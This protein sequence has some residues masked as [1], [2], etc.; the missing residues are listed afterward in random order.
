M[1]RNKPTP[2]GRELGAH[3]ARLTEVAIKDCEASTPGLKMLERCASCAFR[4]GTFPNGCPETLL[5][6]IDCVQSG[7]PFLCHHHRKGE[8]KHICAGWAACV[9]SLKLKKA[10]DK[11]PI[12]PEGFVAP[13]REMEAKKK[14]A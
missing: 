9:S 8:E 5:D 2:E 6:A 13:W 3:V 14:S 10:F 11:H 1:E 12:Q 4:A 7:H